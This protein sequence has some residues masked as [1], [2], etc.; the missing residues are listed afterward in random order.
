MIERAGFADSVGR[1]GLHEVR[2]MQVQHHGSTAYGSQIR[3]VCEVFSQH[4]KLA[5]LR[6]NPPKLNRGTVFF[7]A[8]KSEAI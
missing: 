5:F 6:C 3:M 2:R 1:H 8:G 4:Q 7:R